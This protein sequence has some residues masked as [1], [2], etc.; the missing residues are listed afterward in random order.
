[1][2]A[3]G[4]K[5]MPFIEYFIL[6]ILW[7]CS[8]KVEVDIIEVQMIIEFKTLGANGYNVMKGDSMKDLKHF[9]YLY[10]KKKILIT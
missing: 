1:M 9:I 7:S 10:L 2:K 5:F 4:D 6:E 8:H 3:I